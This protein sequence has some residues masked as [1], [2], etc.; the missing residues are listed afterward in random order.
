MKKIAKKYMLRFF[1]LAMMLTAIGILTPKTNVYAAS[2]YKITIS[3]KANSSHVKKVH[4]AL[5]KGQRVIITFHNS[6]SSYQEKS[7]M[8]DLRSRIVS[9]YSYGVTFDYDEESSGP[10]VTAFYCRYIIPAREA[11]AY[12]KEVKKLSNGVKTAVTSASSELAQDI[13]D[14]LM[15]QEEYSFYINGS[16]DVICGD[17][18]QMVQEIN[19]QAVIFRYGSKQLTGT[20]VYLITIYDSYAKAY[21]YAIKISER[22]LSD[23]QESTDAYIKEQLAEWQERVDEGEFSQSYIEGFTYDFYYDEL[24]D[25]KKLLMQADTVADLTDIMKL[26]LVDRNVIFYCR[27]AVGKGFMG[28]TYTKVHKTGTDNDGSMLEELYNGTARGVCY[29]Y[30]RTEVA[31]LSQWGIDVEYKHGETH[32]WTEGKAANSTGEMIRFKIDYELYTWNA[33]KKKYGLGL[34]TNDL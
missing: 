2:T 7:K 14:H 34:S 9:K 16:P 3:N 13:H 23:F 18:N 20:N 32:A 24:S 27:S 15:N 26:Y 19:R 4:Q 31:L 17:L 30:A 12:S 29:L 21:Y 11:K 10:Y 25:A 5:M 33:D 6:K 8:N 22:M 28:I 1:L